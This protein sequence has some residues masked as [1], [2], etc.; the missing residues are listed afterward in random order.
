MLSV[1]F[2]TT[3]DDVLLINIPE[4][5]RNKLAQVRKISV[6]WDPKLDQ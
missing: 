4:E 1:R 6:A 5:A 2:I 3:A